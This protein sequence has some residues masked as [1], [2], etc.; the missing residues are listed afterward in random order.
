MTVI[1][2]VCYEEHGRIVTNSFHLFPRR[3]TFDGAASII[4]S[5]K[6]NINIINYY[7]LKIINLIL[8]NFRKILILK[9]N[10]N[11]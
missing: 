7:F 4:P 6:S 9:I 3:T 8:I 5:A 2:V 11:K 10:K 1:P